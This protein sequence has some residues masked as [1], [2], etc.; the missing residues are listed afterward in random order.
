MS[1]LQDRPTTLDIGRV[2]RFWHKVE[3]FIP[4]DLQKQVLEARDADWAVR[5]WSS[6]SLPHGTAYLWSFKL[7][8]GRKLVGFDIFLGVFDKSVLTGVVRDALSEQEELEQDERGELEG[9]TCM[10]KV[11]AGPS[12]EPC[13]RRSRSQ[14]LPGPWGASRRRD[15][16]AWNLMSS[17]TVSKP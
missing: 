16:Q 8:P 2:L 1:A 17:R 14:Q 5:T 6:Q 3:F 15:W 13:C 10:A 12:G 7:P 4:F 9:L 11:K